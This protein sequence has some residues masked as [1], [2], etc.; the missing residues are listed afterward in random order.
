MHGNDDAVLYAPTDCR[1]ESATMFTTTSLDTIQKVGASG[2]FTIAPASPEVPAEEIIPE[3][4]DS[5][6]TIWAMVERLMDE[7]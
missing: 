4:F 3:N 1:I 5:A 7:D 6:K 2:A